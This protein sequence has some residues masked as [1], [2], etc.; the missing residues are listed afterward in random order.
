MG[1][2]PCGLDTSWVNYHMGLLS[3]RWAHGL[4]MRGLATRCGLMVG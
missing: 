1:A 4:L 3:G 2:L